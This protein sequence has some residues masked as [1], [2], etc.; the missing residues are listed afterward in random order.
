MNELD[1]IEEIKRQIEIPF[2]QRT[3]EELVKEPQGPIRGYSLDDTGHVTAL[4]LNN[5]IFSDSELLKQLPYLHT[6]ILKFN[7]VE[8][9]T[10]LQELHELRELHLSVPFLANSS[11]LKELKR[12][13]KNSEISHKICKLQPQKND[14]EIWDRY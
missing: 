4:R 2:P 5:T 8:D 9:F 11:F 14:H 12:L 3:Y 1:V 7:V 6:I 10:F 13:S